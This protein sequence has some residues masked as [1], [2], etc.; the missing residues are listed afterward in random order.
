MM[1][2]KQERLIKFVVRVLNYKILVFLSNKNI[3]VTLMVI[4]LLQ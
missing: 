4:S 3:I 2:G 1:R